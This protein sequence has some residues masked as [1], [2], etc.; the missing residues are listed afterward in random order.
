MNERNRSLVVFFCL[1]SV[2]MSGCDVADDG[3]ALARGEALVGLSPRAD[4]TIEPSE[5]VA[6]AVAEQL[7][8]TTQPATPYKHVK[9]PSE[10]NVRAWLQWVMAQPDA[11]G[12]ITDQTGEKCAVGQQGQ[13]WFL[14]GNYGGTTVRECDIPAGKKLFFPLLNRWCVFPSEHYPDEE[15]IA[16]DLPF[17]Q[18]LYDWD[19]D[20]A[21]E[22]T[23]RLDGQELMDYDTMYEDL[24]IRLGELFDLELHPEHWASHA[25]AGGV[26]PASGAGFY[27]QLQPLSAG[28]HVLE[29]GGTNCANGFN[30]DVTYLLHVGP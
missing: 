6:G 27:V 14:A 24:Y 19:R 22:L 3:E 29:L 9:Q 20:N 11:S 12:P 13:V 1:A 16:A 5:A 25:F 18:E 30:V 21:C 26:M 4:I 23:L 28:D 8:I 10:E 7:S 17:I 15:S 2:W